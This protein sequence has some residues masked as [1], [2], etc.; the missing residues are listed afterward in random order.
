MEDKMPCFQNGH[1]HGIVGLN[2]I[3]HVKVFS[4]G[5]GME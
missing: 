1:S 5:P 3:I 4:P 2:E